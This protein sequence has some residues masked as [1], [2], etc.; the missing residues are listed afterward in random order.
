MVNENFRS[1][2]KQEDFAG[3]G[4]PEL[5][6]RQGR[7]ACDFRQVTQINDFSRLARLLQSK[8][9]RGF[10]RVATRRFG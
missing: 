3:S 8:W 10:G 2:G 9:R 7:I 1:A 5:P 4:G 6:K